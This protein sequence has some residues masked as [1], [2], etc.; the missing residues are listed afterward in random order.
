VQGP[1]GFSRRILDRIGDCNQACQLSIDRDEHGGLALI[2]QVIGLFYEF[3]FFDSKSPHHCGVAQS[4]VA[5]V[6]ASLHALAGN[7]IEVGGF[8]NLDAFLLRSRHNSFS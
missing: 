7:R 3:G 1:N 2:A 6:D 8:G 5:P 4:H